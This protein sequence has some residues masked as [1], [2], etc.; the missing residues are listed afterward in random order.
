MPMPP[1]MQSAKLA[2]ARPELSGGA[3]TSASVKSSSGPAAAWVVGFFFLVA[4]AA[5]VLWWPLARV[6]AHF[7][8]T[9]NEGWNAYLQQ[10][11]AAGGR[12]YGE[13]PVYVFAN[14]PPV[15]F[16]LVGVFGKLAG[17]MTLA[18]RWIS[19]LSF[20]TIAALL[21][22]IVQRLTGRWR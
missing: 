12:I 10:K 19:L 2:I 16:Y 18:G 7:S 17:S 1:P 5:A 4:L 21:A 20:C 13:A 6:P 9:Y 8:V 15:S 11:A 22:M 3:V 14:Y